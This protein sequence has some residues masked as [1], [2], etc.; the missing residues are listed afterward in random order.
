MPH[1]NLSD[2]TIRDSV[3]SLRMARGI[4]RDLARAGALDDSDDDLPALLAATCD[5][6]AVISDDLGDIE[7]CDAPAIE[8]GHKECAPP[9][10]DGD[11]GLILRLSEQRLDSLARR[12][13]GA[14]RVRH[15]E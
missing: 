5:E 15:L 9:A 14:L 10:A 4:L 12:I 2:D 6:I 3:A 8:R 1:R 13:E 11:L 7:A